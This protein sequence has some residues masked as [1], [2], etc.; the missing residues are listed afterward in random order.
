MPSD[1]NSGGRAK[2]EAQLAGPSVWSRLE[3]LEETTS[4][5]D[6]VAERARAGAPAGLV[7]VAERQT[8]GRGRLGRVWEDRP[9][10]SLLVS[11]LVGVPPRGQT[12]VPLATGLA[13]SDALRRRGVDAE[14]KWPNDVLAVDRGTGE[15]RKVAGVLVERHD[16]PGVGPYLVIGIGVDVDWRGADRAGEAAAWTSVA[17]ELDHDV[18]RWDV[19]A[20]LMRALSAWLLDVPRGPTQL[21]ASYEARCRTIGRAVEVATPGGAVVG[22]ATGLAPDGGLVVTTPQGPVPV[23]A[24]D[25]TYVRPA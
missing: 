12:L 6:V 15:G 23:T 25:V 16:D 24:G 7:V 4:T 5:N 8:A 3:E 19:L 2:V 14:L 20:D 21:L 18:D 10:G 17:E 22:T 1:G 11:F 9:G 13:V